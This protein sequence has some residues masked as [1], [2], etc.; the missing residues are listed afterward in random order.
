MEH[1]KLLIKCP[2]C[3][4]IIEPKEYVRHMNQNHRIYVVSNWKKCNS[5]TVI[6]EPPHFPTFYKLNKHKRTVHTA[7]KEICPKCNLTFRSIFLLH[8][9]CKSEHPEVDMP[10]NLLCDHCDEM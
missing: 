8:V 4:S 2:V 7:D 1:K 9:H 3:A 10:K 5:C 6:E